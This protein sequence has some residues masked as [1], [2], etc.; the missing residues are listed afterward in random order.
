VSTSTQPLLAYLSVR[1]THLDARASPRSQNTKSISRVNRWD[2]PK[3]V[4][5][6]HDFE[7]DALQ[8]IY[9]GSLSEI[10]GQPFELETFNIPQVPFCQ[11]HDEDSLETLISKWNQSM[12]SSALSAAQDDH[13]QIQV[14]EKIY[15]CKGGQASWPS[16]TS[17][18]RRPDWGAVKHST[19]DVKS[20]G[21]AKNILPG[22]TKLSSKWSSSTINPGDIEKHDVRQDWYQPMAQIFTYCV[23]NNARY[24]YLIT[25]KELVVIR[26][27]P[28]N[29]TDNF[30]S[31]RSLDDLESIGIVVPETA[32]G[33]TMDAKVTNPADRTM[34]KGRLEYRSIP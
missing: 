18:K 15:M 14:T 7:Y 9:D 24:G 13:L 5:K 17:V 20:K 31:Q 2:Q 33:E 23:R 4:V 34:A 3:N 8:S 28:E 32:Q 21:K 29:Q 12:I 10:L 16:E 27:G 11:I 1:N 22:D 25:D 6:W 19:I 26:V 30:D